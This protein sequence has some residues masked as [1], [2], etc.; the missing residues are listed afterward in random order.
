MALYINRQAPQSGIS[1]L[2]A[3]RGRMG[4]TE[5]VHMTKPEVK[6]L[7]QTGL[8][9]LNPQ[10]GLPEYFLGGI[11]KGIK[12][13]VKS[14]LKPENL[15][16]T[17]ASIALPAFG[18]SFLQGL[19]LSQLAS[20]SILGGAGTFL[21]NLPFK[22]VEDSATAGF[23]SGGT[24]YGLGKLNQ[25]M[26]PSD[27]KVRSLS[28]GKPITDAEFKLGQ[29]NIRQGIESDY[30]F[31]AGFGPE[32]N[33]EDFGGDYGELLSSI[34]EGPSIP[35]LNK[36]QMGMMPDSFNNGRGRAAP[37]RIGV[38]TKELEAVGFGEKDFTRSN[39]LA[40]RYQENTV[41]PNELVKE[42]D[43]VLE[44][45]NSTFYDGSLTPDQKGE[46]ARRMANA[47]NK[48]LASPGG[49]DKKT[50]FN[51][52][53]TP[54]QQIMNQASDPYYDTKQLMNSKEGAFNLEGLK[55]LPVGEILASGGVG[56]NATLDVERQ[57]LL[58]EQEEKFLEEQAALGVPRPIARTKYKRLRDERAPITTQQA[59]AAAT[60]G[61]G[62]GFYGPTQYAPI[63]TAEAGGLVAL[64][65]GGRPDFEGMVQG[66]GHGMEDNVIMDIKQKGGLLAVSPKEYVVPADVMSML[67]N[68]N[69]DD[70]ANEMD[71]F[72]GKFRQKKYG[73]PTQPPEM[74]GSTALQSLMKG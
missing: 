5:L 60:K 29:K 47:N 51:K 71:K 69:P 53:I 45:Q 62:L 58:R 25:M 43:R 32:A 70:G 59:L 14:F 66:N 16:P 11:F 64:G 67:G 48:L 57:A 23:L 22:S 74:D 6:R 38:D 13:T 12:N 30:L 7:Q 4:D 28:Q 36:S 19:G 42:F 40:N 44:A 34:Y 33:L 65:H 27:D 68:G 3:Q 18:G 50:L 46:I 17:I 15:I 72:I 26:G 56:F 73:R 31:D 39:S 61:G 10:T 2:L 49:L 35:G 63:R 9:S 20:S 41:T 24:Q 37:Q 8:L 21:G 1:S 54:E 52:T 55:S